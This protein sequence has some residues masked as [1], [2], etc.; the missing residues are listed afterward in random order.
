[1]IKDKVNML[2]K[3]ILD[4]NEKAEVFKVMDIAE[5]DPVEN[6]KP[7]QF[8]SILIVMPTIYQNSGGETSVL[9]VGS[10]F[11]EKGVQVF[12]SS[13]NNDNCDLMYNNAKQNLKSLKG[14]FITLSEAMTREFDFC[15]ATSWQTVYYSKKIKAHHIYFVQDYEPY[16]YEVGDQYLL[17]NHTYD[18]NYDMITLGDWNKEQILRNHEHIR[19]FSIPFP[20]EPSEY[21]YKDRDFE[22]YKDKYE[23]S[24]AIYMKKTG[25]RIP[26]IIESMMGK[27]IKALGDN[28]I[29]LK[30]YYYGLNPK[31]TVTNGENLGKLPKD[32]LRELYYKCDFGMVASMTNVSLVPFEMISTGLPVF[33]FKDGSYS[34]FMGDDTAILLD[35]N[36]RG[37]VEKIT[38]IRS[39]PENI[40]EMMNTARNM[41]NQLSWNKTCECFYETL[42]RICS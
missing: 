41:L 22:S 33:E 38:S 28:G 13:Y 9:R 7:K 30:V 18:M 5:F 8:K 3:H 12:Y 19:T 15:M 34:S 6:I 16:F 23:Y 21:P 14:K 31:D 40:T 11:G 39:N 20:Y 24:I 4:N 36:Y 27:A 26:Y 2:A 32:E 37:L 29:T 25:R 42:L 10:Y 17:A 1:M 35:F